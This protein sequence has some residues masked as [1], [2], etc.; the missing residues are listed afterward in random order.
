MAMGP[1][2]RLLAN[3]RGKCGKRYCDAEACGPDVARAANRMPAYWR[4][5]QRLSE[6]LASEDEAQIYERQP[7]CA[8][9]PRR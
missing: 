1:A 5:L 2:V 3:S 7:K 4:R 8:V 6:Q 9:Y